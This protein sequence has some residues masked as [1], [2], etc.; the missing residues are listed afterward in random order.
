[1]DAWTMESDLCQMRPLDS[2]DIEPIRQLA[3]AAEIAANTFVPHP[4]PPDAASEFVKLCQERWKHDEAYVFAIIQKPDMDFAGTIGIH[5]DHAHNCADVG[6]WIG[7]PFWGRGLATAGLRLII[8]FGF[9]RLQLNRIEAGHFPDNLAS[10]RV[11]QKANMR[12]EGVRRQSI[13][14]RERYKDV[15]YYAILRDDH[16][17]DQTSEAN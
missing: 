9:G 13:L 16:L 5:L 11:M 8:Q 15:V 3:G 1:M 2:R 17:R 10:G 12:F 14:H 4:Y 7:K 6:Y